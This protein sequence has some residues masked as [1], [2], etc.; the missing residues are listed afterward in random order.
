MEADTAVKIT[1]FG[2]AMDGRQEDRI[3]LGQPG[4]GTIM[5]TLGQ[6]EALWLHLKI[7]DKGENHLHAH[8]DEDHFFYILEGRGEFTEGDGSTFEAGPHEGVVIPAGGLY[9]F[10]VLG[11]ERMVM[12]RMGAAKAD[13]NARDKILK[14]RVEV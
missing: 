10:R 12:L 1:R 4:G 11:G 13:G 3:P 14:N 6:T 7:Y 2:S 5:T 8:P 9:C